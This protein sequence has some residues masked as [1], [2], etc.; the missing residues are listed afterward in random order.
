MSLFLNAS[1]SK[2]RTFE[3][4]QARQNKRP[5]FGGLLFYARLRAGSNVVRIGGAAAFRL[6][7]LL[8]S[9]QSEAVACQARY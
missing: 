6:R 8:A 5:P 4:C 2:G 7:F 9:I 3:P 1:D